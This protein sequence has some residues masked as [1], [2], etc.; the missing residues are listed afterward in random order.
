MFS[1]GD[2]IRNDRYFLLMDLGNLYE[3]HPDLEM[4][5]DDIIRIFENILIL[6]FF[7]FSSDDSRV[8]SG[9]EEVDTIEYMRNS[10]D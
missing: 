5:N 3:L 1:L 6:L 8:S 7:Q 9:I 4:R 10:R 2:K